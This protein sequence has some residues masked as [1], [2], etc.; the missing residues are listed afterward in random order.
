MNKTII[1]KKST[2]KGRKVFTPG[3]RYTVAYVMDNIVSVIDDHGFKCNFYKAE[4][5]VAKSCINDDIVIVE[6]FFNDCEW[7]YEA[8]NIQK[9]VI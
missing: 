2:Y 5:F 7:L 4:G 6:E 3:K 1:A 8:E 9:I